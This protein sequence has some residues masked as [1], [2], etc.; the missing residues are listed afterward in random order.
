LSTYV[1]LAPLGPG[2]TRGAPFLAWPADAKRNVANQFHGDDVSANAVLN[3]AVLH[4]GVTHVVVVGHT[5]C[6]GCKAAFGSA[7]PAADAPV[8]EHP[9]LA[10]L[11]PLIK[12]RHSLPEGATIDDLMRENVRA[13]VKNLVESSVR[14]PTNKG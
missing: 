6:G 4:L 2:A 9:L 5:A 3:Y 7:A 8:P 14:C 10:W 13:G 1:A 11:D 12:L